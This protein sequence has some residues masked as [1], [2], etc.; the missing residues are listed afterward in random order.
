LYHGIICKKK[1]RIHIVQENKNGKETLWFFGMIPIETVKHYD[2]VDTYR[3]LRPQPNF[4][5]NNNIFW[6][7][8]PP[9][10]G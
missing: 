2:S 1:H 4:N 5:F 3:W 10:D 9:E 6:I 8:E 7:C